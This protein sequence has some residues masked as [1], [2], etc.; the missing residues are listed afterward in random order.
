M[1]NQD[2]DYLV[3][4]QKQKNKNEIEIGLPDH[5]WHKLQEYLSKSHSSHSRPLAL[6]AS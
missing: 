5:I 6:A 3:K 4:K 1:R 2:E